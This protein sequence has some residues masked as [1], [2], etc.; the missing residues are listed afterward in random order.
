[1]PGKYQIL[2][3]IDR[4]DDNAFYSAPK[5]F[6]T[7][8][9]RRG[10]RGEG[11]VVGKHMVRSGCCTLLFLGLLAWAAAKATSTTL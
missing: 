9:G 5:L 6:F 11:G 8:D 7:F 4:M 3:S 1:M 2:L 10:W